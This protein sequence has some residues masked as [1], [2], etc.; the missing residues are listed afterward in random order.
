MWPAGRSAAEGRWA[1]TFLTFFLPSWLCA[2]PRWGKKQQSYLSAGFCFQLEGE[3]RDRQPSQPAPPMN[4]S[5]TH[6]Q[7]KEKGCPISAQPLPTA[8]PLTSACALA[9]PAAS[10][11]PGIASHSIPALYSLWHGAGGYFRCAPLFFP[12]P[13][14]AGHSAGKTSVPERAERERELRRRTWEGQL[15]QACPSM[16]AQAELESYCLK[17]YGLLGHGHAPGSGT[18]PRVNSQS[19]PS[20]TLRLFPSR[21]NVFAETRTLTQHG[22]V[23]PPHL[24]PEHPPVPWVLDS[25]T[26]APV[27]GGSPCSDMAGHAWVGGKP[28]A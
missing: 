6:P 4:K 1:T 2:E 20:G 5:H 17:K 26:K 21:P 23:H 24:L 3:K 10:G 9:V 19:R 18:N 13:P 7:R 28:P 14:S 25:A 8:S 15:L 11:S 22:Y 12:R 16:A 27:L